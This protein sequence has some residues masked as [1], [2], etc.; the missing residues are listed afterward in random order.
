SPTSPSTAVARSPSP[1]APRGS[2]RAS[3]ARARFTYAEGDARSLSPYLGTM[4]AHVSPPPILESAGVD[5][6]RALETLKT[7]LTGADD[8]EL[9]LERA[10]SEALVFDDGRLKSA[11]Y[12]AVEGFGMRVVA[13][14]TA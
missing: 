12:D 2:S 7:A 4:T 8:G 3:T 10:E 5:P 11:S 1:P 13:G 9:F 14:E 6:A